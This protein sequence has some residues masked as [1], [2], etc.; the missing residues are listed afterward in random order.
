[1]SSRNNDEECAIHSKCHDI[2]IMINNKEDEV[3]E[4]LFLSLLSRYQV[5]LE[6]S[7]KVEHSDLIV[8]NSCFR[9]VIHFKRG[10][11]Q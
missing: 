1:M 7:Q 2:E 9:N 10:E 8:F 4:E 3:I 6:T 5:G 11:S